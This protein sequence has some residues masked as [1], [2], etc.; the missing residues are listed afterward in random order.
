M[1]WDI[2]IFKKM[3]SAGRKGYYF[4]HRAKCEYL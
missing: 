1:D 3:F 2:I 4:M